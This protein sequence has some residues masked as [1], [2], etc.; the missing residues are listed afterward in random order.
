MGGLSL[1]SEVEAS[2]RSGESLKEPITS[3]PCRAFAGIFLRARM[4]AMSNGT[5]ETSSAGLDLSLSVRVDAL[6]V[7]TSGTAKLAAE[8]DRAVSVLQKQVGRLEKAPRLLLDAVSHARELSAKMRGAPDIE[9]LLSELE[10]AA[11]AA[12]NRAAARFGTALAAA[13]R[14]RLPN[15]HE[16][17]PMDAGY[18]YGAIRILPDVASGR[19]HVEFAR[20]SVLRN[21][22]FD[23][24]VISEAVAKFLG[25]LEIPPFDPEAFLKS[26]NAAY[27]QCIASAG[28]ATGDLVDILTFWNRL[29]WEIQP[30]SFHREPT[31]KRFREYPLH[32]FAH[33][34]CRLRMARRF[35][36]AG[37]KLELEVAVHD[38]AYGKSLWVPDEKNSG[39]YFQ[40]IGLR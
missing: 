28:K 15:E 29:V 20:R 30:E 27:L 33:D 5:N 26:L 17:R 37:R 25:D 23:P 39:T 14:E 22:A 9:P 21:L 40:A 31:A 18:T 38:R 8:L 12:E 7:E 19:V 10:E 35:E 6:R 13:L 2:I 34:L 4:F 1:G 36:V 16:L 3:D 11:R 24:E 32:R